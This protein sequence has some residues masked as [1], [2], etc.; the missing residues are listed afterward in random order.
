DAREIDRALWVGVRHGLFRVD[1]GRNSALRLHRV[2]QGALKD[3][4]TEQERAGYSDGMLSILAA[5]APTEVEVR[6]E[7]SDAR[8][9]ELQRHVFPSGSIHS[10]DDAVRRWLVNQ[11]GFLFQ[12][13]PWIRSVA[14][15]PTR[16]LLDEWTARH[17]TADSLRLRLANQLANLYRAAGNYPQ[18]LRLDDAALAGQRRA[19]AGEPPPALPSAPRRG[20]GPRGP[21][22]LPGAAEE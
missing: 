1:W 10:H 6:T 15:E 5:F 14:I 7:H 17:G 20:G 9:A 2:V 8:F 21:R 13:S 22:V 12:G 18:A 11:V 16:R 3:A 4:M 19:L